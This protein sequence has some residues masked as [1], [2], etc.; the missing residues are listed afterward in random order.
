[1]S[2]PSVGVDSTVRSASDSDDDGGLVM[3]INSATSS[4]TN[5]GTFSKVS[6]SSTNGNGYLTPNESSPWKRKQLIDVTPSGSL[7]LSKLCMRRNSSY[8]KLPSE[9]PEAKVLVI[10]TGGTIGMMRNEKNGK[11]RGA[12]EVEP[13]VKPCVIATRVNIFELLHF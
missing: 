1:M 8:G 7:D 11:N 12:N 3:R 10:Y 13:S 5:G 6:S 4:T 2:N 9:N